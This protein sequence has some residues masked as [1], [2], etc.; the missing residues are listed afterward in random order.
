[1]RFAPSSL[2]GSFAIV[3]LTTALANENNPR[4]FESIQCSS[5]GNVAIAAA[6]IGLPTGGAFTTKAVFVPAGDGNE[7]GEYCLVDGAIAPIE[8]QAQ[9]I[10]FRV[11]LPSRWNHK[12][13]HVGGGGFHARVVAPVG[14]DASLLVAPP[15]L[16][17]RRYAVIGS[18]SG[19]SDPSGDDGS[20]LLNREEFRNY[21]GDHLKK[22]HDVAI[23]LLKRRYGGA[24]LHSYFLGGSGGGREGLVVV[25]RYPTDYDGVLSLFPAHDTIADILKLHV[26]ARAM[27]L[28]D[29]LGAISKPKAELLRTKVLAACDALD[30]LKDSVVSNVAACQFDF[31]SMRCP[32]GQQ[33]GAECFSDAQLATLQVMFT[34][35]PLPF[36]LVN[37]ETSLPAFSIGSDWHGPEVPGVVEAIVRYLI[38]QDPAADGLTFDPSQPGSLQTQIQKASILLDATSTDID[39]FV[40]RGGK[41]M[42]IHG[43]SDAIV[44]AETTIAYYERL[45]E[46]YGGERGSKFLRFY[47]IPGY[48]HGSGDSFSANGG[49][50]FDALEGWVE[51][52]VAPGTL[53]V[54]DANSGAHGR[55]RPMCVYPAWPKYDGVGDPNVAVSFSCSMR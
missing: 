39:K 22:V 54:V 45:R 27:K 28:N 52:G 1:M 26:V 51:R 53:T 21:V 3:T 16:V 6:E 23:F 17:A 29:A 30:G 18:D 11:A 31:G 25:Q 8:A 14:A 7:N 15:S 4:R 20:F 19:H 49:P 48:G 44:P 34:R 43:A 2:I 24:P 10:N 37:G 55:S 46:K 42:M 36:A 47:L 32:P 12:L 50:A 38:M 9:S 33:D 41:L 5:L 35:T 40:R 13:A